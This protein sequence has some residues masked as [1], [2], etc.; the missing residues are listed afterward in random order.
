M[1]GLWWEVHSASGKIDRSMGSD[2]C[3]FDNYN[4]NTRFFSSLIDMNT[5]PDNNEGRRFATTSF[6]LPT[7]VDVTNYQLTVCGLV[8]Y[9][10]TA[11][12]VNTG[13][14]VLYVGQFVGLVPPLSLKD[15]YSATAY[16]SGEEYIFPQ[17]VP[18]EQYNTELNI[19]LKA[20]TLLDDYN[21]RH[22]SPDDLL[23]MAG[24]VATVLGENKIF[25]EMDMD[26][27]DSK[28]NALLHLVELFRE[29]S[30]KM[31]PA[32]E[33]QTNT[34]LGDIAK[35]A[36][37]DTIVE[38]RMKAVDRIWRNRACFWMDRVNVIARCVVE[39]SHDSFNKE[40]G[41]IPVECMGMCKVRVM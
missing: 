16:E 2:M 5:A 25:C 10:K 17:T 36:S 12:M 11:T 40:A 23:A 4:I 26:G 29:C 27:F 28:A 19:L 8:S 14:N 15:V 35:V 41:P 39:E 6:V 33:L 30:T 21:S 13:P 9:H 34:M 7:E 22:T 18:I 32:I 38:E 31:D 3:E 1:T 20:L 37:Q 24:K